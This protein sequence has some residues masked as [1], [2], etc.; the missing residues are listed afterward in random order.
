MT[1]PTSSSQAILWG[2]YDLPLFTA[3]DLEAQRRRV[4]PCHLTAQWRLP[5]RYLCPSNTKKGPWSALVLGKGGKERERWRTVPQNFLW[6]HYFPHRSH[7]L[8]NC[9]RNQEAVY[10]FVFHPVCCSCLRWPGPSKAHRRRGRD[11]PCVCW[12][13]AGRWETRKKVFLFSWFT[14]NSRLEMGT[15]GGTS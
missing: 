1:V 13:I 11:Q 15:S 5:G 4:W 12:G 6:W 9:G 14:Q 7:S 2:R 3:E 10:F 8:L